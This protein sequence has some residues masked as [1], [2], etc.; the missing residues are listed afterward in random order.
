MSLFV[1]RTFYLLYSIRMTRQTT[2]PRTLRRLSPSA[3]FS[4]KERTPL[5]TLIVLGSGGHTTEMLDLVKNLNPDC[6]RPII[7]VIANTDTTS[8]QRVKAFP[9]PLPIQNKSDLIL[10]ERS[11]GNRR[12]NNEQRIFYV[13]RPREV[14]QSYATSLFT[15]IYS[16]FH[17][18]WLVGFQIRPDLVIV[19]GPGTCL[20]IVISAFFFRIIGWKTGTKIV[21]IESFCRVTSLSL[22]GKLLY[23]VVDLFAV[24]WE[25][26]HEKYPLTYLIESFIQKSKSPEK[27]N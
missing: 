21:F 2:D 3:S 13:P 25:Q 11:C 15:T 19:N 5:R 23:H 12:M 8:L 6:Y 24:C 27:F 1:A 22:T 14:G 10:T 4:S 7:L 17:A 16:C 9:Q 26:L 18:L 20:P